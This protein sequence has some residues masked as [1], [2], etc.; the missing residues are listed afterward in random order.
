MTATFKKKLK[1]IKL[2]ALDFDGTLT[3]GAYVIFKQDGSE[4][5]VCSRRDSLGVDMLKKAGVGVVVISKETNPVVE[6]RCKKMGI[7]CW[8]GIE[9]G[10]NKLAILRS[11]ASESKLKAEEI[12]YGGDDVTDI[13]CL[14]WSGFGFT[15]ADGHNLCKKA[16]HY[17]TKNPGGAGAVREMCELILQAKNKPIGF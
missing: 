4:S 15:V 5:V 14:K 16:A 3:L 1:S 17:T 6:A 13:P 9:T 11:Y 2:L 8:H 7:K 12:C 10:Q